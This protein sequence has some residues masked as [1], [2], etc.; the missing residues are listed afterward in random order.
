MLGSRGIGLEWMDRTLLSG[1]RMW[2][3]A[4]ADDRCTSVTGWRTIKLENATGRENPIFGLKKYFSGDQM[5][6]G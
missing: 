1:G 2:V 4:E 5:K 6:T 3:E